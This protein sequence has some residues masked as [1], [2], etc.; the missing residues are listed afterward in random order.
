MPKTPGTP[1][2][3]LPDPS[4]WKA[5]VFIALAQLMVVLDATIVNIALPTAQQDLGISDANRQWVITA[6]ALAFGGLLLFG[7][8]IAD[9]WG[10]KRTFVVG[11]LGFAAASAL[12]GAATGEAM[13]LGA[14]ALQGV[15]GALLAPAALSLLAVMFTDAKERAKA[16]GIYGAIAGGGGAVGLILGGFLTEYLDWR[17]TFF[18]NIPFA[19]IAAVGAYLVIREP[20]GARNRSSL[21][22]PGV[23]LSTLGLVALVYG[24]T[25]AES[26]GWSDGLTVAM[27]VAS[28]VLLAA[29]VVT[30]A[31]VS[32]PLLPLRVLTERN[33][34]G[35]YL[36]LG[37]AIIAMF[38]LF[39][40][41]TF[42]LQVVKG[43]SPVR[44]GFAF[45][46]MIA[47]MITGSTQIG[48]RLMTR[49]PPRLLM[50]PGFVVAA[51]GML[52]L[53]QLEIDSSYA[54]LILPAQLLLGLGM[55]T[56]FMPAMS[57]STHGVNPADAGVASA[58]VN[59][60][61]QVGGAIGTALLNT[62]A[63]S[64]TTSYITAHAAGAADPKLLEL[65][66]MVHGFSSAIWWAVGILAVSATI[67]AT[68]I[69]SGR[70][71]AGSPTA[72]SGEGD[73]VEDEVRIPVVAH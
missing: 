58:M 13:M 42:Y 1:D 54:G 63:A 71:G 36:S 6:Y 38:G 73:G 11:L 43:Y 37:L 47:G 51:I 50:A 20:E 32:S 61:Q 62:I 53:T 41:L 70:P 49:V 2:T 64:A 14:R 3:S 17:W 28:A 22:I 68:F 69:N 40:F 67:A 26:A 59:T 8:R 5:L 27:F 25:R 4:R 31:K 57:L 19:I 16:F 65:Q 7:G 35:V 10:R 33:R 46:P 21:D 48:A 52:M 39:L 29:F 55:G 45:L 23:V 12:G 15:F 60:S 30:E 44:T 18:V 9:L 56:A 66:G 24:F 34:G 72:S